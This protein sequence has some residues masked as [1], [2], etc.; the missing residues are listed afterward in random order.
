MSEPANEVAQ[1]VDVESIRFSGYLPLAMVG[2]AWLVGLILF[3]G[4]RSIDSGSATFVR[5]EPML[6]A[7]MLFNP[8]NALIAL[9]AAYL[10]VVR[11]PLSG[12]CFK[13]I[14]VLV[15]AIPLITISALLFSIA[16]WQMRS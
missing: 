15:A 3:V 7:L 14:L 9:L 12:P 2:L 4:W 13:P 11:P 16:L 1:P 8:M 10:A 5:R 6:D